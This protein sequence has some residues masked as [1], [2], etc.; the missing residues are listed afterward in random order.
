[1]A[2]RRSLSKSSPFTQPHG[3]NC[4]TDRSCTTGCAMFGRTGP[5]G[6]TSRDSM[7]IE[8]KLACGDKDKPTGVQTPASATFAGLPDTTPGGGP[9]AAKIAAAGIVAIG[10]TGDTNCTERPAGAEGVTED[11]AR[12]DSD[13]DAHATL[14][15]M[16]SEAPDRLARPGSCSSVSAPLGGPPSGGAPRDTCGCGRPMSRCLEELVCGGVRFRSCCCG[17]VR[18][19]RSC[20]RSEEEAADDERSDEGRDLANLLEL[21]PPESCIGSC[22]L[23]PKSRPTKQDRNISGVPRSVQT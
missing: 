14:P 21:A 12:C 18:G 19:C 1:M 10:V 8:L 6:I 9:G 7:S 13:D 23:L 20:G 5:M 17:G 22:A 11:G 3:K 2:S 15:A 4:A 16:A